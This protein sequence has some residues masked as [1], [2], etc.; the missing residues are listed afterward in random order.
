LYHKGFA[1]ILFVIKGY[2]A[3]FSPKHKNKET[4]AIRRRNMPLRD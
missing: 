4:Y 3:S 2:Y 1:Q